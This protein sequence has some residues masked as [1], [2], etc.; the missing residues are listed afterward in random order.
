[1]KYATINKN[2]IQYI[3]KDR[4]NR[5]WILND[6]FKSTLVTSILEN[7]QATPCKCYRLVEHVVFPKQAMKSGYQATTII[8]VKENT[9]PKFP[10][11]KDKFIIENKNNWSYTEDKDGVA[12]T[13]TLPDIGVKIPTKDTWILPI[14]AHSNRAL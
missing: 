8:L 5:Q 2:K 9:S 6:N 11:L 3:D 4:V 7:D 13:V 10:T 1:M 14:I 12:T